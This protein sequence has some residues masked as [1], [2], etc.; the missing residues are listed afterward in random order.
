MEPLDAVIKALEAKKRMAPNGENYWMAR[1]IQPVL[2]YTN[3]Q[4]FEGVLQRAQVACDGAGVNSRYHF[5][6][7][8]K[9]IEA[10][11]GAKVNRADCYLTRYA[12]YLIAMNGDSNQRENCNSTGI[13]RG[14]NETT[15]VERSRKAHRAPRQS[16]KGK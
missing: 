4:N 14:P 10:G 2:G 11:K 1:D 16:A 7:A 3:W 9:M 12:C 5:I 15:G 13:F 6:E 8:N